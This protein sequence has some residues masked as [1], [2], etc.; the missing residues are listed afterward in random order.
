M[1][2]SDGGEEELPIGG[3]H[4]QAVAGG[5]PTNEAPFHLD[6]DLVARAHGAYH[7]SLRRHAASYRTWRHLT[8]AKQGD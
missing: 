8:R 5:N 7:G 1:G 3:L 6:Y 4:G 2:D